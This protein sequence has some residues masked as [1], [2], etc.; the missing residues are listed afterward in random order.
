MMV[1]GSGDPIEGE[2]AGERETRGGREREQQVVGRRTRRSSYS[3]ALGTG[4]A[5]HAMDGD[6]D[7]DG[8]GDDDDDVQ[9]GWPTLV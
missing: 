9:L 5:C 3:R 1:A 6:D 7:G 4:I 2:E 8:D